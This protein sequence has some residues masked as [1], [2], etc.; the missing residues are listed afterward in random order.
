[1]VVAMVGWV[2]LA[3]LREDLSADGFRHVWQLLG[4]A[5]SLATEALDA[6]ERTQDVP[7]ESL[8]VEHIHS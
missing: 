4:V 2:G 8:V 7:Q 6:V 3:A 5:P 1:M